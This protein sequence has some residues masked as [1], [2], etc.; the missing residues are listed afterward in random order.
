MPR[1][2][3]RLLVNAIER[4]FRNV[5]RSVRA[6]ADELRRSWLPQGPEAEAEIKAELRPETGELP[7]SYGK[8][9]FVMLVVDPYLVHAYWEVPPSQLRDLNGQINGEGNM[10]QAVL[11]FHELTNDME[12]IE[13]AFDVQVDLSARNWYVPLWSPHKRY[14]VELGLRSISSF[15]PLARSNPIRT[16]RAS[17]EEPLQKQALGVVTKMVIPADGMASR[18]GVEGRIEVSPRSRRPERPVRRPVAT[19]IP[20]PTLQLAGP[21]HPATSAETLEKRL[22]ELRTLRELS[23]QEAGA[24]PESVGEFLQMEPAQVEEAMGEGREQPAQQGAGAPAREL[25][26]HLPLDLTAIAERDLKMGIAS[27]L[28]WQPI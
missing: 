25:F 27:T 6:F 2:R 16:P 22:S 26:E 10:T 19:P 28:L 14:S 11:R 8:T 4:T 5:A 23:Y 20:A 7:E 24:T 21:V 1:G 3:L 12:P 17:P 18:N 15:V 13:S 9:R